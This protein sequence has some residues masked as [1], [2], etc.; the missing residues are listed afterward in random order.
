MGEDRLE[1]HRKVEKRENPDAFSQWI[2]SNCHS[3]VPHDKL[4]SLTD[5]KQEKIKEIVKES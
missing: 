2:S 1:K 4:R 3:A 5:G